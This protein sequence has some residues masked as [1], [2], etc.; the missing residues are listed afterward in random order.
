MRV[1][2]TKE[3][4]KKLQGFYDNWMKPIK[5]FMSTQQLLDIE[6]FVDDYNLIK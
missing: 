5:K 4:L 3:Q 1:V 6:K 2:Y